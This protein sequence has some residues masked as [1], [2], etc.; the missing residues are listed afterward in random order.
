MKK[1]SLL[2]VALLVVAGCSSPITKK[3]KQDLAAQ[4][5]CSTAEGDIR[6]LNSEKVNLAKEIADGATSIIPIGLVTHLLM[7]DEG[8]T[9]KVG[10]GEYDRA[11][12]KKIAQIK[13]QC[14][15]K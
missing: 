7:R 2:C 9:F 3:D 5:D 4:V 14:G 12:D 6:V 8:D 10:T 11:L 1:L 13:T 15:I